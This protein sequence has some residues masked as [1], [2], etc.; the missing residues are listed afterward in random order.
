M[1][2]SLRK[3]R[4]QYVIVRQNIYINQGQLPTKVTLAIEFADKPIIQCEV[5]VVGNLFVFTWLQI[6][7]KN[8]K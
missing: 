5:P 6:N 3:K 8:D 1:L 2:Q 7:D 4:K